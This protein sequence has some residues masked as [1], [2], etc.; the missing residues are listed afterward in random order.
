MTK[1]IDW[2]S[3]SL[4]TLYDWCEQFVHFYDVSVEL[5]DVGV[6]VEEVEKQYEQAVMQIKLLMDEMELKE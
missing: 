4:D 6:T 3:I 2:H 5:S 1:Q